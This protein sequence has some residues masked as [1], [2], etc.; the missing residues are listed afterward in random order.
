MTKPLQQCMGGMCSVREKCAHYWAPA[1]PGIRPAERLC[2]SGQ[3]GEAMTLRPVDL[4][5]ERLASDPR[6]A[7]WA[8]AQ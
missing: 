7:Q 4:E 1:Q 2:I 3:D 5:R 8:A 6:F